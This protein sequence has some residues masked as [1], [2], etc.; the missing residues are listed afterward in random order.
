MANS[1]TREK[2]YRPSFQQQAKNYIAEEGLQKAANVALLLG[3]PLL[4]TGEPGSG[5]TQFA[6]HLALDL[7]LDIFKFEAKSTSKYQDLFY[8]YDVLSHF[9]A[10]NF[11]QQKDK[12]SKNESLGDEIPKNESPDIRDYIEYNA[13]GKAILSTIEKERRQS[14]LGVNCKFSREAPHCSVVLIDEIDKA[15]RDFPND[16]LNELE[17]KYFKVPEISLQQEIEVNPDLAPVLVFTSNSEKPLSDAFLRRCVYYHIPF[18]KKDA[19]I[20][21]ITKHLNLNNSQM[22]QLWLQNALELFYY[23]HDES[24][25]S[26]RPSSSEFIDWILVLQHSISE[27][28]KDKKL[29]SKLI[30]DT[31]GV[32][33]KDRNDQEQ[34]QQLIT[35]A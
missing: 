6:Y 22:K 32:L 7:E 17:E 8:T 1:Y 31:L 11:R 20:D 28:D 23:L 14:W 34:A 16:I 13:L 5:K 3:R 4:L 18:P 12:S 30:E 26:R 15:P 29:S 33:V 27:S 9:H 25:L 10:T 19:L 24:D 35:R 2:I 21:I